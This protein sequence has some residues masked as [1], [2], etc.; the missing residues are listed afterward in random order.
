MMPPWSRFEDSRS[1]VQEIPEDQRAIRCVRHLGMELESVERKRG[2]TKGGDGAGR[3]RRERHV[4]KTNM[5]DLV[6]VTHP[7]NRFQRNVL[8]ERL[9][10]V[11]DAAH[12]ATE[13]ACWSGIN[14]AA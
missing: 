3:R 7:H 12:G 1:S 11:L 13:F 6:A 4:V 14:P 9:G 10:W 5:L 2:M 8:K